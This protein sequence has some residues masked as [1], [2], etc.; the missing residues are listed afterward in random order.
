MY[1]VLKSLLA[2]ASLMTAVLGQDDASS[3][4]LTEYTIEAESITAKCIPYGARLTH[5]LV[6][7]RNGTQQ[8]VALGYDEPSD[9]VKD[10]ATNHTYFGQ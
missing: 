6:P 7:D 8:D 10:T 1:S 5:L 3:G 2:L 9:Y 4:P